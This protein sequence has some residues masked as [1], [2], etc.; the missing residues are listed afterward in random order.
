VQAGWGGKLRMQEMLGR[1]TECVGYAQDNLKD[2]ISL[3]NV[4]F[5][6]SRAKCNTLIM[7]YLMLNTSYL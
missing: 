1:H 7:R 2:F 4:F 5:L 6:T 3:C